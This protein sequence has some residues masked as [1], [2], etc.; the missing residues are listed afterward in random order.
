MEAQQGGHGAGEQ[1][2]TTLEGVLSMEPYTVTSGTEE[3]VVLAAATSDRYNQVVDMPE[4]SRSGDPSYL[5]DSA[6]DREIE[7]G[8]GSDDKVDIPAAGGSGQAENT[9]GC[10]MNRGDSE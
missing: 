5:A 2:Q 10:Y 8:A 4:K 6:S 7:Q 3:E 1:V 9:Q